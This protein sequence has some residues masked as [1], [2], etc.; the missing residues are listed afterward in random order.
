MRG[1]EAL[2]RLTWLPWLHPRVSLLGEQ[3]CPVPWPPQRGPSVEVL[4]GTFLLL[5]GELPSEMGLLHDGLALPASQL[6]GGPPFPLPG[7]C[8]ESILVNGPCSCLPNH[9]PASHYGDTLARPPECGLRAQNRCCCRSHL[10][11]L[12]GHLRSAESVCRHPPI[13]P[14]AH[15]FPM[16]PGYLRPHSSLVLRGPGCP[17]SPGPGSW[18]TWSGLIGRGDLLEGATGG[19][20]AGAGTGTLSLAATGKWPGPSQARR[21]ELSR[22]APPEPGGSRRKP[23]E[24]GSEG[25]RSSKLGLPWKQEGEGVSLE[26]P[27]SAKL[28]GSSSA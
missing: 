25:E 24:G 22:C 26:E 21:R 13:R 28:P 2:R 27:G 8:P 4:A 18:N 3:W 7:L 5:L 16:L 23:G 12:Q 1:A 11:S 9:T 15:L 19:S 14:R 20:L 10:S 6:A 17:S